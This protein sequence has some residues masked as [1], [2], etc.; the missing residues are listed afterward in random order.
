MS[1]SEARE[2][3]SA[4]ER[5]LEQIELL[6]DPVAREIATSAIQ[7]LLEL[8]GAGLGRIVEEVAV[9]DD[10]Q[11]AAALAADDLVAHLLL[12]HGLHPVPLEQR[13]RG[14]LAEVRPY[15]ESHGGNVE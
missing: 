5:Q 13:V 1:D 9:R 6:G 2:L 4:V 3:V 10:G 12:L 7:A 14:G 11:L 8:Y 15:L